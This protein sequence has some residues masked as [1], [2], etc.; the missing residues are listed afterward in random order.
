MWQP[1]LVKDNNT[2][3]KVQHRATKFILSSDPSLHEYKERLVSFSMLPLVYILELN[4]ILFFVSC[5]KNPTHNFPILKSFFFC[6]SNTR[7]ADHESSK[8]NLIPFSS[9]AECNSFI[10]HVPRL[11]NSLPPIDL[12]FP[13]LT[14][15]RPC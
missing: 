15:S 6:S 10:C 1:F 2:L 8:L 14:P 12:S 11:W 7:S 9:I 3:E 5:L 13:I 4:N